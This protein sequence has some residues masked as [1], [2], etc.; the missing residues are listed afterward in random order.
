M[1]GWQ[2]SQTTLWMDDNF[3]G[4]QKKTINLMVIENG[5]DCSLLIGH[6]G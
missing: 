5:N 1:Y 6:G 3:T 4:T 2:Q